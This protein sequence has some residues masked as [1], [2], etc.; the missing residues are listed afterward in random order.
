MTTALFL[1]AVAAA[2]AF[3]PMPSASQKTVKLTDILDPVSPTRPS[4]PSIGFRE[5]I[6]ALAL[7]RGR[8]IAT[9]LLDD[10]AKQAI[11][12]LTLALV[13]GSEKP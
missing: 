10:K 12:T 9:E 1:L 13:S 4:A 11:D 6:D 3:W 8:L 2:V 7:V 5:S